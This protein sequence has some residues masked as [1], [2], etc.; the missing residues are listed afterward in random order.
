MDR[1]YVKNAT[2]LNYTAQPV[3]LTEIRFRVIIDH[4]RGIIPTKLP[5]GIKQTKQRKKQ[6]VK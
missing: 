1:N 6:C 3:S 5:Q 2:L 4:R